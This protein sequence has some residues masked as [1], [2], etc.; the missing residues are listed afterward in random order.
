MILATC[1]IT[2]SYLNFFLDGCNLKV[3]WYY[4]YILELKNGKHYTGFT[5]NLKKR[6]YRHNKGLC[7]STKDH[8]LAAV[9][10]TGAFKDKLMAYDFERYLKSGS[11]RAFAQKRFVV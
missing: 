9:L 7:K 10:W 1:P 3:M 8:L 4:V 5:V 2:H 6:L 11:G